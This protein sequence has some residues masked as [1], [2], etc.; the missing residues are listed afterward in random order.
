[1]YFSP[2]YRYH[3]IAL[4]TLVLTLFFITQLATS[5]E[6]AQYNLLNRGIVPSSNQFGQ[7]LLGFIW[8]IPRELAF[9][10]IVSLWL[11]FWSVSKA[12]CR[13]ELATDALCVRQIWQTVK[14]VEFRQVIEIYE[15]GRFGQSIA[16]L[17]HPIL[18][19]GL[20]D[21]DDALTLFLPELRNQETLVAH[22]RENIRR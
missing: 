12:L 2:S 9:F 5:R 3:T 22:L 15:E 19:T 7:A 16:L 11:F 17:Y 6:L 10:F 14:C 21:L 20:L 13:V 8:A 18:P 1:M 4:V